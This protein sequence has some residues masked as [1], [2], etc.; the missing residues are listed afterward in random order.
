MELKYSVGG[1]EPESCSKGLSRAIKYI[2]EHFSSGLRLFEIAHE[3]NMSISCFEKIFKKNM[4]MTFTLYVN[5]LRIARAVKLLNKDG[6]SMSDIAFACGFTN[7]FHFTRMF[8][9]I[10]GISPRDYRKSLKK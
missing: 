10:V 7:Q 4:G 3:A 5:R 1:N 2:N 8:K 6:L 9:K